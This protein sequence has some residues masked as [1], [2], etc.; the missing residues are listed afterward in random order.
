M[1]AQPSIVHVYVYSTYAIFYTAHAG[2][3]TTFKYKYHPKQKHNVY[4]DDKPLT[5]QNFVVG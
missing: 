4:F 2:V 3:N 1:C 5:S